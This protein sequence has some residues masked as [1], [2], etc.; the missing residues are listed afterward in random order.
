MEKKAV[1]YDCFGTDSEDEEDVELFEITRTAMDQVERESRNYRQEIL[2]NLLRI[3]ME[4]REEQERQAELEV[5][6]AVIE[7]SDDEEEAITAPIPWTN[8]GWKR[9]R[10]EMEGLRTPPPVPVVCPPAPKKRRVYAYC[11]DW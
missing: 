3:T 4:Y 1:M 7:E 5:L 9:H 8:M 2:D 6:D 11:G 10:E